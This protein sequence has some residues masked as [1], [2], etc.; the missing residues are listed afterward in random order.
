MTTRETFMPSEMG[1]VIGEEEV[2]EEILRA[3]RKA[4]RKVAQHP[5]QRL[6][7]QAPPE[8]LGL[9]AIEEEEAG[10]VLQVPLRSPQRAG[11]VPPRYS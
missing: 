8:H 2:P 9:L 4:R 1:V 5:S 11:A 6:T 10:S 7:G 3:S